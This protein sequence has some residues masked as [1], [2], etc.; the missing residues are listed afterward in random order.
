MGPERRQAA[1]LEAGDI[2]GLM[3][4]L[5]ADYRERA[6]FVTGALLNICDNPLLMAN[7]I[8]LPSGLT[9][10][11]HQSCYGILPAKMRIYQPTAFFNKN[12][13]LHNTI[14]SCS[15]LYWC[16]R[17]CSAVCIDHRAS[18]LVSTGL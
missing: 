8:A 6:Y 14:K 13:I 1:E 3:E 7:A 9:D 2:D 15:N 10:V 16:K 5:E 4:L 18:T 11:W 12:S 17:N